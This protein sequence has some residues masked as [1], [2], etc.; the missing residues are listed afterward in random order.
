MK[1]REF[2]TSGLMQR[3]FAHLAGEHTSTRIDVFPPWFSGL[4]GGERPAVQE[5]NAI[6]IRS[7]GGMI[8]QR[9]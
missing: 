7:L 5:I 6:D 2:A 3:S 4:H 8:R 1:R 9:A